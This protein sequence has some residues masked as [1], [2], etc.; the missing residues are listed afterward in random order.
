MNKLIVG[1]WKMYPTLSDSV[2][3]A[4][5]FKT[6]LEDIK[7][8]E[9]VLAPP[10]A[11]LISVKEAMKHPLTHVHLAAQNIWPDDQGA[12]T[13]EVSAYFLKDLVKYAIVGHSERRRNN[14]EGN[15]IISK[16]IE[17]CL[18]WN[19]TPI[20]CVGEK[21]KTIG[22]GSK[23]NQEAWEETVEQFVSALHSIPKDKFGSIFVAYEPVWAI[24]YNKQADS[25]YVVSFI[26]KLK[27][28][29]IEEFG[30]KASNDLRFIYGGSVSDTNCSDYLRRPEIEGFL[31]GTMS[32]RAKEFIDICRQAAAI[33]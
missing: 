32:V 25:D 27:E 29:A 18:K 23:I 2:V 22:E 33:K 14:K 16:K 7:G 11:W 6:A 26:S 9:V 28:K 30:A 24:G 5:S 17:A 1:N 20:L 19:V 31:I 12:F 8:V 15:E 10:S 4:T 3:L 13:G 21:E